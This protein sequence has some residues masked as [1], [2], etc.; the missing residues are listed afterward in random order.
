[1]LDQITQALDYLEHT[2]QLVKEVAGQLRG[3]RDD[4]RTKVTDE[5]ERIRQLEK[6]NRTLKDKPGE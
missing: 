5:L 4:V 3:T 6:E 1:M 2:D